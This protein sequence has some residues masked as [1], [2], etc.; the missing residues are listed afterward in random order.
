M[1]QALN[2]LVVEDD[3]I[4]SKTVCRLLNSLPSVE[5]TD[6]ARDLR[7][8]KQQLRDKRYDAVVLDLGLPDSQGV[9]SVIDFQATA[10]DLPI[11]VLTGSS[12]ERTALR[13]VDLGAED[14][15]SKDD[16]TRDSLAR[17]LSFAME[18]H[19]HKHAIYQ[20]LDQLKVSLDG[21][22]HAAAT[23]PLTGLANRR[24]LEDHLAHLRHSAPRGPVIAAVADLDHFKAINDQHGHDVGDV[25][26]KEFSRRL[27]HCL[28]A[29]DF[30]ARVGGDE[31]VIIFAQLNRSEADALGRRLLAHVAASPVSP[32]PG[33]QVSFSATLAMLEL[34]EPIDLEK[35]L[36]E[37]H[38]ALL[39]GKEG[40]RR[41]LEF[42]WEAGPEGPEGVEAPVAADPGGTQFQVR[43]L[44]SLP[45]AL[46]LGYRLVFGDGEGNGLRQS[47]PLGRARLRG[48]LREMSLE[49]LRRAEHWRSLH[50]PGSL[51]ML[52]LEADAVDSG[53]RLEL[54]HLMPDEGLRQATVLCFHTAFQAVSGS[55]ALPELMLLRKAGFQLGVRGVGDGSTVFEHL[56][57]LAPEWLRVDPVL[58]HNVA[59]FNR[60]RETLRLLLTMLRPLGSKFLA[61]DPASPEDQRVLAELGF[62]GCEASPE[63]SS[64]NGKP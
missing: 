15:L 20:D 12:D 50:M 22:L 29:G 60:K 53:L 64:S 56:T 45:C 34:Q 21:A 61:E 51:L 24:G 10:P 4:D 35:I 63:P 25:V 13:S 7:E 6:T 27:L 30:A 55:Q 26:L 28:R 62:H 19:R 36:N 52:D 9:D 33:L 43:D 49:Q 18:R 14:C 5:H 40:G 59:R 2:F 1:S 16:V 31:F 17:A 37:T 23:D 57:L 11:V 54:N 32:R 47:P 41:R 39:R 48:D 58:T 44:C 3:P 8:A 38:P 46:P 42:T